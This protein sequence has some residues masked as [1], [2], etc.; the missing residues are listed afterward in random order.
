MTG[1]KV[2][3]LGDRV[4]RRLSWQIAREQGYDSTAEAEYL[5]VTRLQA[6][7]FVSVDPAARSRGEGVVPIGTVDQLTG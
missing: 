3:L 2:R 5:A 4:S 7:M 6:D 1:V